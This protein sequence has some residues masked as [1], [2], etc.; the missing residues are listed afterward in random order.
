M[1]NIKFWVKETLEF[2][3]TKIFLLEK[4]RKNIVLQNWEYCLGLNIVAV[5]EIFNLR[6]IGFT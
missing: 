3:K 1:S 5:S 4:L 2:P 6:E